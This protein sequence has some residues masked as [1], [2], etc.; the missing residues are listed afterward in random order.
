M[1]LLKIDSTNIISSVY[2]LGDNRAGS[3][4][5]YYL[6][7]LT[8]TVS[9]IQLAPNK[10]FNELYYNRLKKTILQILNMKNY[11]T[12]FTDDIS[13]LQKEIKAKW[14]QVLDFIEQNFDKKPDLNAVLF[15]VGIRELGQ[16][17]E[18]PFSKED[19]TRLMHIANCKALSYSGY[20]ELQG[21][22]REGWPV[23]E[24]VKPLPNLTLI[25]QENLLRQHLIE[26]FEREEI[27]Q[28][29]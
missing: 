5:V 18:K 1:F 17:P 12:I 16:I 7:C 14:M 27:I 21:I 3:K 19:K 6:P 22:N 4:F 24:N 28:F 20:Y 29:K 26:Y 11:S 25:E 2:F 13:T 23:W 8:V 9:L 15:L 10:R